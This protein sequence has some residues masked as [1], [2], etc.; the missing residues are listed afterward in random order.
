MLL[1]QVQP[2]ISHFPPAQGVPPQ[3]SCCAEA[4]CYWVHIRTDF[5]NAVSPNRIKTN[6]HHHYLMPALLF[7]DPCLPAEINLL[8]AGSNCQ[9]PQP[10]EMTQSHSEQESNAL[11][12]CRTQSVP[13]TRVLG[14]RRAISTKSKTGQRKKGTN[15]GTKF[16]QQAVLPLEMR[17]RTFKEI[18]TQTDTEIHI[19]AVYLFRTQFMR[20]K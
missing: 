7:K 15:S 16:C 11:P 1:H 14:Q 4:Q 10:E 19:K 9:S 12:A 6:S 20:Y 2:L 3:Q 8:C 13:H 5:E 17:G 18:Q